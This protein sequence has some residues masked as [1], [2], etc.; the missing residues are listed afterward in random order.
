M[1]IDFLFKYYSIVKTIAYGLHS[2]FVKEENIVLK[3]H[4]IYQPYIIMLLL[5]LLFVKQSMY[6]TNLTF[7]LII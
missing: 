5:Y 3:I 6:L 1:I 4:S 2:A 7:F